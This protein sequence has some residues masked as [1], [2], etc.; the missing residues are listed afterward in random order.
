MAAK[1]TPEYVLRLQTEEFEDMIRP[2]GFCKGK[3]AA[4]R[5][6]AGWYGKY[7]FMAE[8]AQTIGKAGLRKERLALKGVG[9]ETKRG[10]RF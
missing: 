10:M 1:L 9:E 2:C 8:N 7:D 5:R 4:V 6:L 3:A